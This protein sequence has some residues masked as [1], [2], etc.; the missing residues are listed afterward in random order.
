MGAEIPGGECHASGQSMVRVAI[1]LA[2]CGLLNICQGKQQF[3]SFTM[4]I[5]SQGHQLNDKIKKRADSSVRV[6]PTV[7]LLAGRG[8]GG[9]HKS[10]LPVP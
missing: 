9:S 6:Q 8:G 2:P 3:G 5:Q 4:H 1:I 7:G 10:Q